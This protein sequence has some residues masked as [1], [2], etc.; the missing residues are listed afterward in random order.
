MALCDAGKV[1]GSGNSKHCAQAIIAVGR[2]STTHQELNI[3]YVKYLGVTIN[4]TNTWEEHLDAR[5]TSSTAATAAN[6]KVLT[7]VKLP[8]HLRKLP[9]LHKYNL[10]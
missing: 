5:M 2:G 9:L 7:Q 3:K 1:Q 10:W 4:N 6:H 8:V